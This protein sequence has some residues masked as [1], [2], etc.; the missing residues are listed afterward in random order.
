MNALGTLDK[1]LG[2]AKDAEFDVAREIYGVSAYGEG[3]GYADPRGALRV[4]LEGLYD[5]LLVVLEAADMPETRASLAK[6]WDQF[7]NPKGL[8]YT[9]NDPDD[10][11]C[12][13]PALTF[14]GRLVDGL[15]ISVS[16][17][18]PSEEA[19]TLNRLE[20]MLRDTAGL[21]LRREMAPTNEMDVQK[22]M[23]D[24][25]SAFF[26]DFTKNP[27]ISGT[28]KNFKP[29]CGIRGVGA[30]IEFKFV[31]DKDEVATAYSGI[32]E[33][34]AAY[35]S[36][37]DWTYQ[38]K[39]YALESYFRGDLKRIH[40]TAWEVYLVTGPIKKAN[41]SKGGR[42]VQRVPRNPLSG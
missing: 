21:V 38:A 40:A 19:W 34:S 32:V 39:P 41:R 33:D 30:A 42:R 14:L 18:L 4:Y 36:S 29:D 35:K 5:M 2:K 22:I 7:K 24:Y 12:E 6:A 31:K 16:K 9:N 26:H 23:H 13:S 10:Q 25:L 37:K 8:E 27:Q 1:S 28:L 20:A 3:G 11:S 15:R 17:E